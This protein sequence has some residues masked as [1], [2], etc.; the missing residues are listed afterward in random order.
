MMLKNV[1]CKYTTYARVLLSLTY[2]PVAM[3]QPYEFN[4]RR[5]ADYVL[6]MMDL[7]ENDR[8]IAGILRP[9]V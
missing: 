4:V 5:E 6:G 7:Y 9:K 3:N 2:N 1:S 8:E